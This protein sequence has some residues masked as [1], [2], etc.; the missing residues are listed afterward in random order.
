[1]RKNATTMV[2]DIDRCWLFAFRIPAAQLMA[3]VPQ[4]LELVTY[5]GYGFINVVVS[6]LSHMRPLGL[7]AFVGMRYRHVAYRTYVRFHPPNEQAIEGLYFFRSDAD[8]ALIVRAGNLLTDF[9]FNLAAI[10]IEESRSRLAI[11]IAS[12]TAPGLARLDRDIKPDLSEGSP[13]A[14]LAAAEAFLK[15]KPA[16]ISVK[17]QEVNVLR[18][19]RD[20]A[21]WR[22]RPVH[23]IEAEFE[24]L[25][26]LNASF[27]L[28][29]ELEP[30]HYR[31]NRAERYRL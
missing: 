12:E 22:A 4:P 13:F 29:S 30:V 10:E 28:C 8:S 27:E 19:T 17:Q 11:H 31:W 23:V 15:Y 9:Q 25:K 1:V 14:E 7:P 26:P 16:G 21:A 6:E 20:E 2:G 3:R 18:I 24:F 5:G